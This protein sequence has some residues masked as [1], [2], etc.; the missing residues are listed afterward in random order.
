MPPLVIPGTAQVRLT[1]NL[2][3]QPWAQNVLHYLVIGV[4]TI[5][6]AVATEVRT[7]IGSAWT[8]SGL[9]GRTA[10]NVALSSVGIRDLRQANLPEF[11]DGPGPAGTSTSDPL[12]PQNSV[13]VTLRTA[14]AGPSFRGRVYLFGADELQNTSSGNILG[15][16]ATAAE[17]FIT[18]ILTLDVAGVF[19]GLV[20]GVASRTLL[21]TNGVTG[22]QVRD[23]VWDIQ[24]RR[25]DGIIGV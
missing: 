11:V 16:Y 12:P 24:R 3:G 10:D 15:A 17:A 4:P 7:Q 1:W 18:G 19:D 21:Q 22:H 13:V 9:P 23:F 20:L 25:R 6:Q 8:A 2:D 5:T 14:F